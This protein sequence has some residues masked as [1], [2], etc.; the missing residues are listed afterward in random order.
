MFLKNM[1]KLLI[2]AKGIKMNNNNELAVVAFA[3]DIVL[4]AETENELINT[5]R[6]LLSE[7]KEIGLKINE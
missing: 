7:G 2:Q 1:R 5:T 6:I 3:N 4:T